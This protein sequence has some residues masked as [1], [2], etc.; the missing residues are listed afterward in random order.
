MLEEVRGPTAINGR[1]SNT[2]R[3]VL[4]LIRS[5]VL[6]CALSEHATVCPE[7]S[8]V[9]Q[10]LNVDSVSIARESLTCHPPQSR[11]GPVG[12]YSAARTHEGK[13]WPLC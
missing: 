8:S 5:S 7:A 12:S 9:A 6:D 2:K 10:T 13:Q 1:V 11:A 4:F 3:N